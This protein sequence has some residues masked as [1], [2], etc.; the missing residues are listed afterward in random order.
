MSKKK[1]PTVW[2]YKGLECSIWR[3]GKGN[4]YT[5]CDI[6]AITH[7]ETLILY[8]GSRQRF[9]KQIVED[10]VDTYFK[11]SE[12]KPVSVCQHY[13][14]AVKNGGCSFAE[15]DCCID[16]TCL[17]NRLSSTSEVERLQNVIE[18]LEE[19]LEEVGE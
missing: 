5:V 10:A 3:T 2:N 7:K 17:Y 11:D 18:E 19:E 6:G 12:T 8:Y 16:G 4:I 13:L 15:H 14:K 1:K 9:T